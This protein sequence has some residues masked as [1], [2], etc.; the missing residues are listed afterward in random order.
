MP[1]ERPKRPRRSA[2]NLIEYE[3]GAIFALPLT[4][5]GFGVGV[6]ARA[7]PVR[8]IFLGYLFGPKRTSIPATED[9]ADL[10][11]KDAVMVIR[12]GDLHLIDGSWPLLGKLDDWVREQWSVP[13]FYRCLE[14]S[15]WRRAWKVEYSDDLQAL[16]VGGIE[17]DYAHAERMAKLGKD[18]ALYGAGAAEIA[19]TMMLDPAP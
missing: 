18:D 15:S 1:A 9:V 4:R 11:A 19:L 7:P 2:R 6:V 16:P 10:Q 3:E 8:K 12:I 13:A 14:L 17:V 5:G